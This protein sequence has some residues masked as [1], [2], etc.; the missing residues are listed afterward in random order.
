MAQITINGMEFIGSS[1]SANK[2]KVF[3]DG[4][5]ISTGEDKSINITVNGNINHLEV[6]HCNKI[7][8]D[9][10]VN[11]IN[12]ISGNVEIATG[13]VKGNIKSV[14]GNVTC[15]TVKGRIETISGSISYKP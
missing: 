12:T 9:G 5:E 8:V 2:C 15:Q 7:I 1:L 11:N 14:S 6:N 3:I 10:T 13:E 4:K